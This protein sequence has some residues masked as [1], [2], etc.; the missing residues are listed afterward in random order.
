MN[1]SLLIEKAEQVFY[2]GQLGFAEKI[3]MPVEK[4]PLME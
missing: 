4:K 3:I 1:L 2:D